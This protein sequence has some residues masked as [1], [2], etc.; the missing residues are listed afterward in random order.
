MQGKPDSTL[1][2]K[3]HIDLNYCSLYSRHMGFSC[4]IVILLTLL[5]AV[6][7][8]AVVAVAVASAAAAIAL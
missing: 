8:V 1:H 2:L 5:L 4:R 6:T 3:I 7:V